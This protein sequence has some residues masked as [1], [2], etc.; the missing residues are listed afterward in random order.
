M[1][2]KQSVVIGV[3]AALAAGCAATADQKDEPAEAREYR[4]GSHLPVR[5]H[6]APIDV[7]TIDADTTSGLR[8]MPG[9]R[10]P[11]TGN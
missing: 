7:K 8:K 9:A 2:P 1:I 10:A 6:S 5:D 3:V 4:T 11:G